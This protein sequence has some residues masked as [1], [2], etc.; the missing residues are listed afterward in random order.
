[1]CYHTYS[2]AWI[3]Q[4]TGD[5]YIKS[6]K[7]ILDKHPAMVLQLAKALDSND[8][9][10]V[11]RAHRDVRELIY[12]RA[13]FCGRY[14][15][16]TSTP[17]IHTSSNSLVIRA[18]D[19]DAEGSYKR[20]FEQHAVKC[21]DRDELVIDS[22]ATLD[23]ALQKLGSH[24]DVGKTCMSFVFSNC[25][26]STHIRISGD[27][28]IRYCKV[29]MGCPR[30]I[31]IKFLKNERMLS[32]EKDYRKSCNLDGRYVVPM[33]SDVG[34]T[35]KGIQAEISHPSSHQ[36]DFLQ[37]Y[38]AVSFMPCAQRD[39]L[40]IFNHETLDRGKVAV[41]M[42]DIAQA[43]QH[44]HSR[45]ICHGDL[46]MRNVVLAG[47]RFCLVD[48]TSS[49]NLE[50]FYI[51]DADVV[52]DCLVT[53]YLPPEMFVA[54]TPTQE[55]QVSN[56]W[57]GC[58]E[59][60]AAMWKKFKPAHHNHMCYCVRAFDS[61]TKDGTPRAL[62]SLPYRP[63]LASAQLDMWSYGLI[64]FA[65]ASGEMILPLSAGDNLVSERDVYTAARWTTA[66]LQERVDAVVADPLAADLIL[67]LLQPDPR[68]RPGSM[69]Q[70]LDHVYFSALNNKRNSYVE[71]KIEGIYTAQ[72]RRKSLQPNK[73]V[74]A[75]SISPSVRDHTE[76][77]SQLHSQRSPLSTTRRRTSQS[78]RDGAI[79]VSR[80]SP[81]RGSS[82]STPVLG[83]AFDR[84][85]P[86]I[87]TSSGVIS[88]IIKVDSI[89]RGALFDT[90]DIK[91]PTCFVVVNQML[92]YSD[93][94]YK[95]D[96]IS[97]E[98]S[99]AVEEKSSSPVSA[100]LLTRIR[101]AQ[102]WYEYMSEIC[103]ALSEGDRG[104]DIIDKAIR[105]IFGEEQL[106][107]YLVD[108]VTMLPVV[109][110]CA[111]EIY[112]IQITSPRTI[113]PRILPLMKLSLQAIASI[114]DFTVFGRC[115]GYPPT[116]IPPELS[117]LF[118][119]EQTCD[120]DASL[121]IPT[122]LERAGLVRS[123]PV[124]NGKRDDEITSRNLAFML[125]GESS[126]HASFENHPLLALAR[127]L[128]RHDVNGEYGGLRR[129]TL[130]DDVCTWT[131]KSHVERYIA[132]M[133]DDNQEEV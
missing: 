75:D 130:H 4:E 83:T 125:F 78:S 33:I 11:E 18:I 52:G 58:V 90:I 101:H 37:Q 89:L 113:I 86:K 47:D 53:G 77:G 61:N 14:E 105:G 8:N 120:V 57:K 131:A 15:L 112:P 66:Q 96:S 49:A 32:K 124:V 40:S 25:T 2:W 56:Y 122:M 118:K 71:Q 26:D 117:S 28:F 6:I 16:V 13:L 76:P 95:R 129:L 85:E 110:Q 108:E 31:C 70:I 69:K 50:I 54:L 72:N 46:R 99:G 67:T 74:Q 44:L 63:V 114:D 30:E 121:A 115:F 23:V 55:H 20:I 98:L 39:L 43:L 87:D 10:A 64:L 36:Y 22:M 59:F 51:Q 116:A 82:P 73:R 123:E 5:K 111:G 106:Y 12:K 103:G 65:L 119:A 68:N 7:A 29:S 81:I 1:M 79:G 84:D 80:F 27:E 127:L 45:G 126:V 19:Y 91:L 109:P 62:H 94:N 38:C 88:H 132:M 42:R 107:L 128:A 34:A 9:V 17:P 35:L 92:H 21:D 93:M 48:L 3:L 97:E 104:V 100:D 41:I 60:D 133:V 102:R 24:M